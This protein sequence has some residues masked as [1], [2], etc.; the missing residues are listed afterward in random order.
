VVSAPLILPMTGTERGLSGVVSGRKSPLDRR[1]EDLLQ[2]DFA[3]YRGL[4]VPHK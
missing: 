4:V 1:F 3:T 2:S